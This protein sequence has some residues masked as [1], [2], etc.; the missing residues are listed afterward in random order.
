[1]KHVAHD[2]GHDFQCGMGHWPKLEPD[3]AAWRLCPISY[4]GHSM[5]TDATCSRARHCPLEVA[6]AL[7]AVHVRAESKRGRQCGQH[8]HQHEDGPVEVGHVAFGVHQ[9]NKRWDEEG[10][11]AQ[12]DDG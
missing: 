12:L 2:D 8:A 6:L 5:Q 1:M 3:A 9:R 11:H 4:G 7:Q 10:A